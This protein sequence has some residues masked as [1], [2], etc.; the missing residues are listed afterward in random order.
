MTAATSDDWYSSIA[1]DGFGPLCTEEALI[2]LAR[3]PGGTALPYLRGFIACP[4]TMTRVPTT[5]RGLASRLAR[6][7][8]EMHESGLVHL[9]QRRVADRDYVYIAV[10]K[11]APGRG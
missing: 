3:E 4:L 8:W 1:P 9:V 5:W 2:L 6:K 10:R 11:S 7:A